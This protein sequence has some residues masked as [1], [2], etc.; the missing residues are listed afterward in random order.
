[1]SV[2]ASCRGSL[3]FEF[4]KEPIGKQGQ[5]NEPEE[6]W[7][8]RTIPHGSHSTSQGL[9]EFANKIPC[10]IRAGSL[11]RELRSDYLLIK[12]LILISF[13][14]DYLVIYSIESGNMISLKQAV[15]MREQL[16]A[17]HHQMIA[18]LDNL[19]PFLRRREEVLGPPADDPA[20]NAPLLPLRP[21]TTEALPAAPIIDNPSLPPLPHGWPTDW[22]RAALKD[23]I[24][25]LVYGEPDRIWTSRD[26]WEALSSRG[27]GIVGRTVDAQVNTVSVV[28]VMLSANHDSPLIITMRGAGRR[29]NQYKLRTSQSEKE[30]SLNQELL[31][32]A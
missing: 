3:W 24:M 17:E 19:I 14:L 7:P 18:A 10:L 1:V 22:R 28:M 30:A 29:P 26:M 4:Y 12:L 20:V 8:Y 6:H 13:F 9:G 25:P 2:S 21:L 32:G 16:I 5:H 23:F 11:F 27:V 15:E 31:E